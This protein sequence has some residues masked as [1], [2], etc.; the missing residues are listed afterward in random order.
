MTPLGVVNLD[1]RGLC[2]IYKGDYKTVLHTIY[3]LVK[4]LCRM[5][6]EKNIFLCSSYSMSM[7][8]ND[9]GC[10]QLGP[11]GHD[12]QDLCNVPLNIA[13][14]IIYRLQDKK[15]IYGIFLFKAYTR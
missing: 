15:S 3:T 4:A 5:V 9:H 11:Q 2:I 7:V 6:S 10:S 8:D 14:Y 12:W 13:T 1:P